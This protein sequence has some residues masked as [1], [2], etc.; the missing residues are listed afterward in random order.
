[1][2]DVGRRNFLRGRT[3]PQAQIRPPWAGEENAFIDRCTRCDDCL[4]ACPQ[5]ILVAG[6][7]GYPTVDFSC[8]ECTFCGDCVSACRPQALLR[9]DGD[10]PWQLKAVINDLCLPRHGIECRS[11]GDF[12]N[13][14]AIRFSPR[15]GGP[16]LAEIDPDRC[17][18]CG[19][20]LAP[21]PGKAISIA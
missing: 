6:E 20:C 2:V 9:R 18:G 13:A 7:G 15:L 16:P 1:M 21:C 5:G 4:K 3:R 10:P 14:N 12:C 17:T 8:G 11:C 19:A